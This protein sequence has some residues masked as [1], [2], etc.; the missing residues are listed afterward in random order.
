MIVGDTGLQ[1]ERQN[2]AICQIDA[3]TVAAKYLVDGAVSNL[4][5]D[6]HQARTHFIIVQGDVGVKV[7]GLRAAFKACPLAAIAQG[8]IKVVG[9]PGIVRIEHKWVVKVLRIERV[10]LR[11]RGKA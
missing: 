4:I 5:R 3:V 2:F 10:L 8:K 6:D 9:K 1:T 11:L 7:D